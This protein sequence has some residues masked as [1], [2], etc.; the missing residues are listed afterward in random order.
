MKAVFAIVS[1]EL[2]QKL[3]DIYE[4]ENL[5]FNI[6]MQGTGSAESEWLD[7]M[8]LGEN[9]KVVNL[10]VMDDDHV[11]V[12]YR[13]LE[14]GMSLSKAGTGIVF[15]AAIDSV[16]ALITKLCQSDAEKKEES[17]TMT[18][19][20]CKYEL[21]VTI[22]ERGSFDVVK[23]AARLAGA[24]GGTL[25][26]GLGLGGEEAVK[27]LG[28]NLQPEKDITLIVVNKEDKQPIMKKILEDAGIKS[29]SRGV[30]FSIPVDSAFGLA[31]KMD[32]EDDL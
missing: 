28:I 4:K 2:S 31:D 3:L 14:R 6:T 18:E 19:S 5:I 1:V 16:S 23:N 20:E 13:R 11:P 9:K 29:Q 21:I 25:I 24:R 32:D 30:C 26:H 27:F 17:R 7:L 12:L 10:C 15:A 8:G 22:S